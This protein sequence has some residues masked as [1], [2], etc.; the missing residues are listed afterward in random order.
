MAADLPTEPDCFLLQVP[1]DLYEQVAGRVMPH[2]I[3]TGETV[4]VDFCI[5]GERL[6]ALPVIGTFYELYPGGKP[7]RFFFKIHG[8]VIP[9]P[10][11]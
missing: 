9:A 8:R 4:V 3:S 6:A 5:D 7:P 1:R 2:K 10:G 11:R